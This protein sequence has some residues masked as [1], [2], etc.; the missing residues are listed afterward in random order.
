MEPIT[1]SSFR[2]KQYWD[3]FEAKDI[4]VHS[5]NS[6]AKQKCIVTEYAPAV[7]AKVRSDDG[8]TEAYLADIL[9]PE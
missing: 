1:K 8:V 7:F 3:F 6:G 2:T 4:S 5:E 9:R